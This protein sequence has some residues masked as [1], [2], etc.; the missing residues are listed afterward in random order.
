MFKYILGCFAYEG[1]EM[2]DK[3]SIYLVEVKDFN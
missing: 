3:R 2:I 1:K